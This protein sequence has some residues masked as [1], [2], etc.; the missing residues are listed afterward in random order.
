MSVFETIRGV[1]FLERIPHSLSSIDATLK[2]MLAFQMEEIKEL[3]NEEVFNALSEEQIEFIC[4]KVK[5][6]EEK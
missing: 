6:N 2:K 1:E 4:E 5:A 3:S